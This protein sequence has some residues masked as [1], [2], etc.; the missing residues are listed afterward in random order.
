M[1]FTL[2]AEP[3][4]ADF[5]HHGITSSLAEAKES[6]AAAQVVGEV[7]TAAHDIRRAD[8]INPM[9]GRCEVGFGLNRETRQVSQPGED[10]FS[11]G[12]RCVESKRVKQKNIRRIRTVAGEENGLPLL[13][14]VIGED[15]V[16]LIDGRGGSQRRTQGC[17]QQGVQI[18]NGSAAI[19]HRERA[20]GFERERRRGSE[21]Y[22]ISGI[23]HIISL[24][25]NRAKQTKVVGGIAEPHETMRRF[26]GLYDRRGN[27]P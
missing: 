13:P 12:S 4:R 10:Y 21:A 3:V 7:I 9:V 1:E 19:N 15:D 24:T 17:Q 27:V 14:E 25:E 6:L 26:V 16:V 20:A 23:V 22:R 11:T 8:Y 18:T 2:S 5:G